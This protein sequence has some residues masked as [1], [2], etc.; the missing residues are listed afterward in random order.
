MLKIPKK[1]RAL[2]AKMIG[3]FLFF[4]K[5]L[6]KWMGWFYLRRVFFIFKS[7]V[8]VSTRSLSTLRTEMC[9]ILSEWSE[10]SFWGASRVVFQTTFIIPTTIGCPMTSKPV[11]YWEWYYFIF[12]NGLDRAIERFY[13]WFLGMLVVCIF[14]LQFFC[15]ILQFCFW[16]FLQFFLQFL[17]NCFSVNF[18]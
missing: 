11:F 2:R 13:R 4:S 18:L 7:L 16:I 12:D 6:R 8:T 9:G 3:G 5:I 14:F 15:K 1:F 10:L 17:F